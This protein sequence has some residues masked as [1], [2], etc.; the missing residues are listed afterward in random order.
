MSLR[1]APAILI[2]RVVR[3]AARRRKPGGGSAVPGLV[4][5]RIAPGFLAAALG[6]FRD[7][8]VI[9]SGSSGKSTTTYLVRRQWIPWHRHNRA[10]H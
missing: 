4:V 6:S 2:G 5:N 10:A 9:V 3:A 7:G 8:L 1:H